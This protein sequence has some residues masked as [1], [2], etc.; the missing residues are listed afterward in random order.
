[1]YQKESFCW[2]CTYFPVAF[3]VIDNSFD[4]FHA[5]LKRPHFIFHWGSHLSKICRHN[6]IIFGRQIDENKR[7][8]LL[9]CNGNQT[10]IFG[11][12]ILNSL[13]TF[14][15]SQPSGCGVSPSVIWTFESGQRFGE[16]VLHCC[17]V[18]SQTL[19]IR[20]SLCS[21]RSQLRCMMPTY[22]KEGFYVGVIVHNNKW[23]TSHASREKLP[24]FVDLLRS[25]N[26]NPFPL[27]NS[28]LKAIALVH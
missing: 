21:I 19:L 7:T 15:F 22:I 2:I 27:K 8:P 12:K 18:F 24:V 11:R 4:E 25:P 28:F 16:L 13:E 1:M 23:F 5:M 14:G 17:A 26:T 3:N 6:S 10:E 9:Q 20:A